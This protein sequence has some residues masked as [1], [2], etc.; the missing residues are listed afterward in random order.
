MKN[1]AIGSHCILELTGCPPE[2]LT[3]EERIREAIVKAS[4]KSLSTLLSVSSHTLPAKGVTAL[5]LLAESHISIHTCPELGYAAC[6][7]FTFGSTTKPTQACDFLAAYLRARG[8]TLKVLP[9]GRR[10]AADAA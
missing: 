10:V 5:G 3:S 2:M 1:A 8:H 6:D 4:Q 7:I 9:R